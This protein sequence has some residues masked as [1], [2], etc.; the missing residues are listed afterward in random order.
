MANWDL[1]KIDSYGDTEKL[2]YFDLK[3][4][5][6]YIKINSLFSNLES[7]NIYK[8]IKQKQDFEG[9]GLNV[10]DIDIQLNKIFSLPVSLVI[11]ALLSSLLMLNIKIKKTKTFILILGVLLSVTMYYIYYFFGLLGSN[12]KIP[13]LYISYQT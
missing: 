5:F 2:E 4:N 3:T 12:N 8:L 11:F 13:I 7:L 9:V 6:D 1:V 10:S